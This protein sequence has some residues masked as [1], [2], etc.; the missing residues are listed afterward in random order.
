MY[1]VEEALNSCFFNPN[2]GKSL[3]P[4]TLLGAWAELSSYLLLEATRHWGGLSTR[5]GEP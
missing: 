2:L 5:W 4:P 3:W 1:P